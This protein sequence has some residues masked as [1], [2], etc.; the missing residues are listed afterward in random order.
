MSCLSPRRTF[1]ITVDESGAEQA[2]H[3][4]GHLPATSRVNKSKQEVPA[5]KPTAVTLIPPRTVVSECLY[6]STRSLFKGQL[7]QEGISEISV[8][9]V[10]NHRSGMQGQF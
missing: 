7:L 1:L 6:L 2:P 9:F 3:G 5:A 8:L 10:G 4:P